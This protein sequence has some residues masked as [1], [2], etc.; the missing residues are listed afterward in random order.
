MFTD[1]TSPASHALLFLSLFFLSRMAWGAD[2]ASP[3]FVLTCVRLW[4]PALEELAG[5]TEILVAEG[6]VVWLSKSVGRP[7]GVEVVNLSDRTCLPGFIDVH[8]HLSFEPGNMDLQRVTR[9]SA[10]KTLLPTPEQ[11]KGRR[12]VIPPP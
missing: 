8:V 10:M 1:R 2:L 5:P 3:P 11:E 12:E 9:S 4:D 7:E 6:R